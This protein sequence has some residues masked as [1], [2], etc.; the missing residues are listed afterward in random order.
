MVPA[1]KN[2]GPAAPL[3]V[4]TAS[5]LLVLVLGAFQAFDL[6]ENSV[7]DLRVQT[8]SAP[9]E[10]TGLIDVILLDQSSLDWMDAEQGQPWPWDRR[11]FGLVAD[12]L[13]RAGTK[14]AIFDVIFDQSSPE[15]GADEE[16][17]TSLRAHGRVVLAEAVNSGPEGRTVSPPIPELAEAAVLGHVSSDPDVGGVHRRLSPVIR[18][19]DGRT[20]PS[21]ALAA[22]SLGTGQAV[23]G[24]LPEKTLLRYRG[25][26]N[27]HRVFSAKEIINSELQLRE[28][29]TPQ[30]DPTVFRDH[31]VFFG[32]SA[33]GLL[34]LR[35]SPVDEKYP[36]VLVHATALDNLLAG[37]SPRTPAWYW[38]GLMVVVWSLGTAFS[39]ARVGKAVAAAP[40]FLLAIGLPVAAGWLA[41]AAGWWWPV[42]P[43]VI[44]A[45]GAGLAMLLV[46]Y[47]LEGR[48]KRFIQNAFGQ[49]L[50]P[51]VI[52]RLVSDPDQLK[53]GGERRCLSI[54]FSDV[55][56]FTG[57][58][59]GLKDDPQA[60]TALLNDYLSEMTAI[61]YR[62]GGTIDKYEGDAIIA[63]WNAPLD[64]PDHALRAVRASLACQ[65]RLAEIQP[66]LA[67]AAGRPFWARIGLNT[68]DVVIG[69]M[70]SAQRFNYT[71]LG[72]AGNLASRLEGINKLFGTRFLVS[73]FTKDAAG[74]AP[75]LVWREIGRVRVVGKTLPV[76][77]YEPL[78]KTEAEP[79]SA[80]LA[81]FDKALRD[82]YGGAF[83]PALKAFEALAADDAPSRCYAEKTRELLAAPPR[84]WDGVWEAKEK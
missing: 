66:R 18:L 80:V 21:L 5:A 74:E 43:P 30:V 69:N 63:F 82:W 62:Y 58:S 17:A 2:R 46:N 65:A 15:A 64:L 27:T 32:Y 83:Q 22:W 4:G 13:A 20:V 31:Y 39:V 79:L 53:L 52:A 68:G 24:I 71:F 73:A 36:G 54:F 25:P 28:G 48:Q 40:L 60:L 37:D 23:P 34:D 1:R 35:P 9:S 61:I 29:E 44:G 55:A 26:W 72:D 19:A 33:Q 3:A 16:F 78:L 6:F 59:E 67:Q 10:A 42:V 56:G 57:I 51:E 12:F 75:D 8:L 14:A 49:Y 38:T 45:L 11:F 81:A 70:G 41:Y 50:S 76:T 7:W 47:A 77:V 84:D